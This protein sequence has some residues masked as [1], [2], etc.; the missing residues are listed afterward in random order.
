MSS[1]SPRLL[2]LE[3]SGRPGLVALGRGS[4]I[5]GLRLF[6][7]SR[8]H[9]RDLAPSVAELLAEQG[10]KPGQIDAVVVSQGPG[11]YTGLRV[12][13][14][15]AKVF[16]YATS[17][18]L[19]AIH[20]FDI[21]ALQAPPSARRLAILADA[22]QDKVYVQS[23]ARNE[24]MQPE[25]P[26]AILSF[27]DWVAQQQSTEANEESLWVTGPGL[28][29][30][31]HQLPSTWLRVELDARQPQPESLLQLGLARYQ[32]GQRDDLWTVE[33]LYLR[34]SSAEERW[35]ARQHKKA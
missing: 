5:V 4:D 25:T 31:E 8:K 16:A 7:E 29:R 13:I 30:W 14:M 34:P 18:A 35:N 15:S 23:F 9:A 3:T 20:T 11:T 10:W 21:L 22:Q 6:D 33:P 2:L 27:A 17:C 19:L 28:A 1:D 32:A 12:G 26:L 24:Q